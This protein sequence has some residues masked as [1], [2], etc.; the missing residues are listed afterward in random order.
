MDAARGSP[1]EV[2]FDDLES[3]C[4]E[5][6]VAEGAGVDAGFASNTLVVRGDD[7][8]GFVVSME[9]SCG[10]DGDA[11]RGIAL[12]TDHGHPFFR[13]FGGEG[14]NGALP[15]ASSKGV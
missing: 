12:E 3:C 7:S 10:A 5:A 8:P 14:A 6:N 11:G 4:V 1:T 15:R 9:R 13:R 2:T